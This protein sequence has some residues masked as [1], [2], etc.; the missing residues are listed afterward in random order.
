MLAFTASDLV[1]AETDGTGGHVHE[2]HAH[3]D[4][5]PPDACPDGEHGP[6]CLATGH[7]LS[8][9]AGCHV[10]AAAAWQAGSLPCPPA[11]GLQ[12][13]SHRLE[14]PPRAS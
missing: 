11:P 10:L 14:R 4:L 1:L 8:I 9:I 6:E 2:V 3:L 5:A 13:P 7:C 12:A